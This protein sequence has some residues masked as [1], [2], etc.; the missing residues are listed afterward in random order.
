MDNFEKWANLYDILKT[1]RSLD[2][3]EELSYEISN[4]K[5]VMASM[6]DNFTKD[7]VKKADNPFY[8]DWV[9]EG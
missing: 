6:Y 7:E 4:L 5:N 9:F 2:N 1:L 8:E 3:E